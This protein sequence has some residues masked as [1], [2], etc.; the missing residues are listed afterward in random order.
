MK[1]VILIVLACLACSGSFAQS[2]ESWELQKDKENIKVFTRAQEGWP[3]KGFRAETKIKA[4]KEALIETVLNAK[5]FTAW[6]ND[7]KKSSVLETKPDGTVITYY[8]LGIP[9]PMQNRDAVAAM[10][11]REEDETTY[12]EVDI[13]TD[14][15]PEYPKLVRMTK[16]VGFWSFTESQ[17]GSIDVVY[18]FIADPEGN[19]P[20][21]LANLFL[22]DGPYQ[23]L[24]NLRERLE[25]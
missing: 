4:S 15:L 17:N 13:L 21:W 2:D 12:V 8:E 20:G 18:Q 11:V 23:T 22:V 6:M 24:T 16:S 1:S 5:E 25:K 7:M 19:V 9:W 14:Y 3:I 10:Q